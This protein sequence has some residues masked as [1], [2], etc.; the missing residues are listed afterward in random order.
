MTGL[1]LSI[2]GRE[3]YARQDVAG[4]LDFLVGC[5]QVALLFVQATMLLVLFC[6]CPCVQPMYVGCQSRLRIPDVARLG[7]ITP[8]WLSSSCEGLL[9]VN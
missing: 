2:T 4:K 6:S 5:E 3:A 1:R 7:Q 9:R 8:R